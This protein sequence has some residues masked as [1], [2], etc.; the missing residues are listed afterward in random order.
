MNKIFYIMGK[1]GSGKDS[2][3]NL[4]ME[5]IQNGMFL[6]YDCDNIRPLIM[7]TTRPKRDGE[8][9]GITYNFVTEEQ[10]YK[11]KDEGK[12]IESR[13]YLTVDGFKYYYVSSDNINLEQCSYIMTS[14][15][16]TSYAEMKKVYGDA[17][18]PIVLLVEKDKRF[19][20]LVEREKRQKKPN[21]V[22]LCRRFFND[23]SHDS[24]FD[25]ENMKS[26]IPDQ[27][28]H[29]FLNED[30]HQCHMLLFMFIVETLRNKK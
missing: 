17:M 24:E 14:G 11:D 1:S 8:I 13:H 22:E 18:V 10:M 6:D 25:M 12:I 23:E 2:I 16:P 4:L 3:F 15:T 30:M 20:R 7:N 29:N 5:D 21:Y 27:A 19:L 9:D 28:I 26:L